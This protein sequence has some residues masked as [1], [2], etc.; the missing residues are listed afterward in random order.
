MLGDHGY[1][2]GADAKI[3]EERDYKFVDLDGMLRGTKTEK[4]GYSRLSWKMCSHADCAMSALH[5]KKPM[6]VSSSK[7]C[8]A[9][10]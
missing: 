10:A 1:I 5:R 8:S 7:A 4:R 6:A 2:F 3:E 9:T